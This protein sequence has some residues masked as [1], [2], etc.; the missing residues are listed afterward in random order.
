MA[1][2]FRPVPLT[3]E[4]KLVGA[5]GADPRITTVHYRYGATGFRPNAGNLNFLCQAFRDIVLPR[6]EACVSP[7]TAWQHIEATDINDATG[8]RFDFALIGPY[9]GTRGSESYAGNVNVALAKHTTS[10][11]RGE[12]GRLFVMDL[13]RDDI[14]DSVIQGALSLLLQA[15]AASLLQALTDNVGT[16]YVPVVASKKHASFAPL[17]G[18]SFDST[19]DELITRLKG[20]RKHKRHVSPV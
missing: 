20:H 5:R 19:S 12:V 2:T 1:G 9:Q 7:Q 10:R 8:A 3:V 15:L 16:N 18:V 6:L 17:T 4:M 13:E 14:I 11:A